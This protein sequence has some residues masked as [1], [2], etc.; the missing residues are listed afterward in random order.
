MMLYCFIHI[1]Y[2]AISSLWIS[3]I[4]KILSFLNRGLHEPCNSTL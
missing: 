2:L 1:A 3:N 4:V